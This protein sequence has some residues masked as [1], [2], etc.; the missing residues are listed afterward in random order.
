MS[1]ATKS[2]ASEDTR[3]AVADD[4]PRPALLGL[5]TGTEGAGAEPAAP[6][7]VE[8]VETPVTEQYARTRL[9]AC[10]LR[11]A[12]RWRRAPDPADEA[13]RVAALHDL[14]ILDTPA[15]ERFDRYTRLAAALFDVPTAL[16]SLVDSDRQWFKS[17]HGLDTEET[18]RDRAF[19]A[20]AILETDVFQVPDARV[21][22][23]FADNPLVTQPPHVRFYAG[24]PLTVRGC[25]RVGTL[26][27][28]DY[29]P[30]ELDAKERSL[31]RD[32]GRLVERE[33]ELCE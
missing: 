19:C 22:P 18:P 33:L 13:N 17:R 14:G 10:L 24:T 8:W 7:G 32:L 12:C 9:R 5:V 6:D 26:C 31:L 21:H 30:R 4:A 3:E 1:C 27:L 16:V 23:D 25:H 20:H 28:I 2:P 15:E 11:T 29:L